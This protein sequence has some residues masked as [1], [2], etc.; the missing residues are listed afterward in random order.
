MENVDTPEDLTFKS[1]YEIELKIIKQNF[2]NIAKF[3]CPCRRKKMSESDWENYKSDHL[4]NVWK[5]L[6]MISFLYLVNPNTKSQLLIFNLLNKELI[7]IPCPTCRNHYIEYKKKCKDLKEVCKTKLKFIIWLIDFHN[8]V[9]KRLE[10]K[11]FS[12]KEI[13]ELYNYNF[14]SC[15]LDWIQ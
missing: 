14:N 5:S 7:K 4:S 10:K 8:N 13:F 3:S 12:Y 9:N 11:E 15:I 6:H 2:L 1:K